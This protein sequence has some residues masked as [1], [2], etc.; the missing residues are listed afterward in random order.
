MKLTKKEKFDIEIG[1]LTEEKYRGMLTEKGLAR[2]ERL[3]R[4]EKG[5]TLSPHK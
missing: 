4:I 1:L 3:E 5:G 2:L